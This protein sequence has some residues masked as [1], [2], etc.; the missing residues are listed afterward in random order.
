MW[1]CSILENQGLLQGWTTQPIN[2]L[3]LKLEHSCFKVVQRSAHSCYNLVKY[4]NCVECKL[5]QCEYKAS[6]GVDYQS[7]PLQCIV[8]S[9]LICSQLAIEMDLVSPKVPK[10]S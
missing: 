1:Y 5:L 6:R 8:F 3:V 4:A 7:M 9:G 10:K 2:N